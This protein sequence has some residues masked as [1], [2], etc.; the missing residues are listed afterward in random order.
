MVRQNLVSRVRGKHIIDSIP[1]AHS[2]RAICKF[3]EDEKKVYDD[4]S[5]EAK[6]KLVRIDKKT[7]QITWN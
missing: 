6:N 7:G 4:L 2:Q 5:K 1:I 3:T